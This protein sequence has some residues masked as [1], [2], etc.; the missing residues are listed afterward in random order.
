MTCTRSL[1]STLT[2]IFKMCNED[3]WYWASSHLMQNNLCV[4]IYWRCEEPQHQ[5]FT[6]VRLPCYSKW[7]AKVNT[8][9]AGLVTAHRQN[10]NCN[11]LWCT[12]IFQEN[13]FHSTLKAK[14][15]YLN[16]I[17]SSIFY[18]LWETDSE[19]EDYQAETNSCIQHTQIYTSLH[20]K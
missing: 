5:L 6:A 13:I 19:K 10:E 8:A 17:H 18:W 9:Y 7:I 16:D 1:S 20:F 4:R 15:L 3:V 12:V 11:S 14:I 2:D